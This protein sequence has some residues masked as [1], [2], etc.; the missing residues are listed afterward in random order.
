MS[1]VETFDERLERERAE[2]R[3][4]VERIRVALGGDWGSPED[5]D[6]LSNSGFWTLTSA[7]MR[8]RLY[9]RAVRDRLD[10]SVGIHPPLRGEFW[11]VNG[12]D[13][14]TVA[15]S[16][17][18]ERIAADVR[19]RILE[20]VPAWVRCNEQ[21]CAELDATERRL[22]DAAHRCGEACGGDARVKR[23]PEGGYLPEHN[24]R[25]GDM[26]GFSAMPTGR[27]GYVTG[28]V[29]GDGEVRVRLDMRGLSLDEALSL[30]ERWRAMEV[31]S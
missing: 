30:L 3:A 23:D 12:P 27:E 7:S 18:P 17:A 14:I 20:H 10:V 1:A 21:R 6:N 22:A 2:W 24:Y 5:E 13:S 25:R 28:F 11:P 9:L 16:K 29:Y 4:E 8:A 15:R 31:K 19:R 26:L